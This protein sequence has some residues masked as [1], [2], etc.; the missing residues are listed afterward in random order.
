MTLAPGGQGLRVQAMRQPLIFGISLPEDVA[1][2][3]RTPPNTLQ[4]REDG[5]VD[6]GTSQPVQPRH[7]SL[8]CTYPGCQPPMFF[9]FAAGQASISS[10][11]FKLVGQSEL[12]QANI[13]VV[14]SVTYTELDVSDLSGVSKA[15]ADGWQGQ[16]YVIIGLKVGRCYAFNLTG[17]RYAVLKVTSV[18]GL[19]TP[20]PV[21]MGFDYLYQ[22]DGT[23]VFK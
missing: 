10:G 5:T 22:G 7:A 23:G 2:G 6:Q 3:G 18:T 19:G 14:G 4:V 16:P 13:E 8:A 9:D 20:N 11:D 12:D 15:P 1:S 17:G 21:N